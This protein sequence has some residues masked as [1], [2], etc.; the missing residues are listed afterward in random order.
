MNERNLSLDLL[1]YIP[2]KP[3]Q[4]APCFLGLNFYGN[5]TVHSDP[6]IRINPRWMRGN[7]SIGIVNN[8]ATEA[9]R[10]AYQERWQVEKLINSGYALATVYCGDTDPDNY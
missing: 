7:A 10:G 1:I 6:A 4:P 9:T 8:R 5:Q 3:P 2:N